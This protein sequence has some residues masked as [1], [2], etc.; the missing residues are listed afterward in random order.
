MS[1][2]TVWLDLFSGFLAATRFLLPIR[3]HVKI[4]N[5]LKR[6]M[7]LP[8]GAGDPGHTK[9]IW[10]SIGVA[11]TVFVVVTAYG[12][13][14]DLGKAIL[15]VQQLAISSSLVLAG[16]II[17]I[18]ILVGIVLARRNL[19]CFNKFNPILT[20]MYASIVLGVLSIIPLL[21]VPHQLV[22]AIIGLSSGFLIMGL[23]MEGVPLARQYLT[24]QGGVLVRIGLLL[25][26]A[27]KIIQLKSLTG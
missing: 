17:G 19:T 25:F 10:W 9:S 11:L 20:V 14:V 7:A 2:L 8:P 26:I 27:S 1:Q 13:V 18:A 12:V 24:F 4:D 15:S 6:A 23:I 16:A 5:W 22:P 21:W 3:W